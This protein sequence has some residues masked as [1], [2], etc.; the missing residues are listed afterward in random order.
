MKEMG[1]EWK[2]Q[3]GVKGEKRKEREVK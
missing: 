2:G 3:G 1:R